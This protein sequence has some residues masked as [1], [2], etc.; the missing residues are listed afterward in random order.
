M[1]EHV[2]VS[3]ISWVY[4]VQKGPTIQIFV[5]LHHVIGPGL[6]AKPVCASVDAQ[7]HKYSH[8]NCFPLLSFEKSIHQR[9]ESFDNYS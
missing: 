2:S 8:F 4:V 7:C 5:T 1:N 6:F 3:L 9:K